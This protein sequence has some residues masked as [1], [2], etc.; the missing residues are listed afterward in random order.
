MREST[1]VSAFA[2]VFFFA[3]AYFVWEMKASHCCWFES[4]PLLPFTQPYCWKYLLFSGL[5][6]TIGGTVQYWDTRAIQKQRDA[7][8]LTTYERVLKGETPYFYLYLRP[9]AVRNT[10]GINNQAKSFNPYAPN[11]WLPNTFDL[12]ELLANALV[13]Y[14]PVLGLG[15]P[16][17]AVGAGRL[18]SDEREW[19]AVI[20]KLMHSAPR[21]LVIPGSYVGTLWEIG[22]LKDASLLKKTVFVM[23]PSLEGSEAH[24]ALDTYWRAAKEATQEIGIELPHYSPSGLVF[25][26]GN[27]GRL[28]QQQQFTTGRVDKGESL[29]KA[30]DAL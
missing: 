5:S 1:G 13:A 8:A 27:D 18:P 7:E 11:Y 3:A 24:D 28:S 15:A 23:P 6:V 9:F 4:D 12:E 20:L 10:L 16:G 29:R 26:I 2:T 22:Q 30:I 19:Q 21:I 14:G 25:S 17:E